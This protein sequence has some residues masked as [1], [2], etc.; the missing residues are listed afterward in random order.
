MSRTIRRGDVFYIERFGYQDGS[1]QRPGRPGIVVSNDMNNEYSD[2][3]EIVYLTT[4]PKTKLPTHVT[5]YGTGRV[6]TALCEQIT[7]VS[8]NRLGNYV[9]TCNQ[10]EMEKIDGA[11][12]VSL[13][14]QNYKQDPDSKRPLNHNENQNISKAPQSEAERIYQKLYFDLLNRVLPTTTQKD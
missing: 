13:G 2:C 5:V 9:G 14:I 1:E 12:I 7:T 8:I 3:V 6:S 11:I 10:E 4:Q